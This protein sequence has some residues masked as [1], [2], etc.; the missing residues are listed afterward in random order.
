MPVKEPSNRIRQGPMTWKQGDPILA[1]DLSAMA[2]QV[3]RVIE[4]GR[5]IQV[6]KMG[7]SVIVSSTGQRGR[8]GGVTAGSLVRFAKVL[9]VSNDH[10]RCRFWEPATNIDGDNIN[11]AKPWMLRR[12]PFDG[13]T[14]NYDDGTSVTYAYSAEAVRTGTVGA[15]V[16][17]QNLTPNYYQGE[18]L[19]LNSGATDV[20][21]GDTR[22]VWEDANTCGRFW[23]RV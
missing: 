13:L 4:G 1:R 15:V 9:S 18:P 11:V 20:V 6:N 17:T 3:F 14:I 2:D 12:T 5:G 21:I 19:R 16:E 7:N 22:L 10:I 23:A 8:G